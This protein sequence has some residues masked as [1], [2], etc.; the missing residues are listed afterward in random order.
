MQ[1]YTK[2]T[3]EFE[4]LYELCVENQ[5]F[6]AGSA[7]QYDKL[8][9]RNREGA[10]IIELTTIIWLCSAPEFTRV[11]IRDALIA[12]AKLNADCEELL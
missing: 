2:P 10:P 12:A 4:T 3:F 6:T 7:K 5:W 11:G 1:K 9:E 8:F